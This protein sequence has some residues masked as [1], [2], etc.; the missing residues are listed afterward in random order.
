MQKEL[1]LLQNFT[2]VLSLRVLLVFVS[3]PSTCEGKRVSHR[4]PSGF[5]AGEAFSPVHL[6]LVCASSCCCPPAAHPQGALSSCSIP[7]H[8]GSCHTPHTAH[9]PG[10]SAPRL[11]GF[12]FQRGAGAGSALLFLGRQANLCHFFLIGCCCSQNRRGS[13]VLDLISL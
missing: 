4:L 3:E 13:P 11:A 9:V 2:R 8:P 12:A 5:S 1:R 6:P 7:Q 10:T